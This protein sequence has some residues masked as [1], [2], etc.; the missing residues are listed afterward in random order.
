LP[1][2]LCK[3]DF[4]NLSFNKLSFTLERRTISALRRYTHH[5]RNVVPHRIAC[6]ALK[7]FDERHSSATL[8]YARAKR[9]QRYKSAPRRGFA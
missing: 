3:I 1:S 6:Q 7:A 8:P 2:V 9:R 4:N 5:D